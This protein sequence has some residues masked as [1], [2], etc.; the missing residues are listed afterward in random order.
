MKIRTLGCKTMVDGI[1]T[2]MIFLLA[3]SGLI[4]VGHW[5]LPDVFF[6]PEILTGSGLFLLLFVPLILTAS[7][8]KNR[9]KGD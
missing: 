9:P 5:L 3:G 4:I 8:L 7:Y 1:I 6:L 2:A